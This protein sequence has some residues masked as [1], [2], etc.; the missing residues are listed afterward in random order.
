MKDCAGV[1]PVVA[2]ELPDFARDAHG[3]LAE[4]NRLVGAQRGANTQRPAPAS[5]SDARAPTSSALAQAGCRRRA[6]WLCSRPRAMTMP[7]PSRC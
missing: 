7:P 4:Q 6:A 2:S 1:T 3:N 5:L